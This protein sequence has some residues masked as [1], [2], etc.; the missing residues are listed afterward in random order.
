MAEWKDSYPDK[1]LYQRNAFNLLSPAY[2]NFCL[3]MAGRESFDLTKP[4]T[5][6][7]LGAGFGISPAGWG[8]QVPHWL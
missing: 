5:Y 7:E 6:M 4:F 3:A 1:V 8:A 2:I